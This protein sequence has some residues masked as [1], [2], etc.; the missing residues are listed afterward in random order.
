M[1]SN[2]IWLVKGKLRKTTSQIMRLH[3]PLSFHSTMPT[4]KLITQIGLVFPS[5]LV[6]SSQLLCSFC[7]FHCD[8]CCQ[9]NSYPAKP[10]TLIVPHQKDITLFSTFSKKGL[11][12]FFFFFYLTHCVCVLVFNVDLCFVQCGG[13]SFM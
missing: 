10:K 1:P 3:N 8:I 6:L 2:V 11:S 5:F 13:S 9:H 4:L 12:V 7:S